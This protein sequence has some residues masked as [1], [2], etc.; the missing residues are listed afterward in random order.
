MLERLVR[1]PRVRVLEV[2]D[3]PLQVQVETLPST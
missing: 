3:D 1:L 2:T